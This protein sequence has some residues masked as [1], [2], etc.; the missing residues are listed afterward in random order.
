M[1]TLGP[2]LS[3]NQLGE[4]ASYAIEKE[5]SQLLEAVAPHLSESL[6]ELAA[7]QLANI[8]NVAERAAGI[9]AL[10]PRMAELG[11]HQKAIECAGMIEW[12]AKAPSFNRRCLRADALAAMSQHLPEEV[13]AQIV[14]EALIAAMEISDHFLR[15]YAIA[16]L[17]PQLKSSHLELRERAVE[18]AFSALSNISDPAERA[19]AV[20]AV[21]SLLPDRLLGKALVQASL[22]PSRTRADKPSRAK[23]LAALAP[24]LAA[25]PTVACFGLWTDALHALAANPREELLLDIPALAPVITS[26]GGP[27]A[28]RDAARA[29]FDSAAL[30]P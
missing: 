27:Q 4:V 8:K 9:A 7:S 5:K 13:A 20:V 22:L 28:V 11:W 21:T 30:W 15:V 10:A 12:E 17:V 18:S 29:I 2:L 1:S 24:R 25:L 16:S 23:A 19:E 6:V 3:E 14:R 26:L